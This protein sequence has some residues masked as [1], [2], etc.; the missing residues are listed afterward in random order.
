[1]QKFFD[2][3]KQLKIHMKTFYK[4]FDLRNDFQNIV[5]DFVFE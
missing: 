3:Q 1:M 2:N 5:F 4:M